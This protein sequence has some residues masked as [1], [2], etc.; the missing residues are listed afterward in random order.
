MCSPKQ[1]RLCGLGA[2]HTLDW[3]RARRVIVA[4]AKNAPSARMTA[5]IYIPSDIHRELSTWRAP[6]VA[7]DFTPKWPARGSIGSSARC[8]IPEETVTNSL[9]PDLGVGF[10]EHKWCSSRERR[11]S[12]GGSHHVCTD[13]VEAGESAPRSLE[14]CHV[15]GAATD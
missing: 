13:A 7:V 12:A 8:E 9:N 5:N 3:R 6:T 15:R 11:G 4:R 2:R 10:R 14:G 1:I